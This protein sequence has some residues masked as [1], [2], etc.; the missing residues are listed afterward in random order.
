MYE[1]EEYDVIDIREVLQILRRHLKLLI[2]VPVIFAMLGAAV[3][4]FVIN[5]VYE[6]STTLIVRQNKGS[7]EEIDIGDV[8]LSKSLVYTYAEMAKSNTVIENTRKALGLKE[9]KDKSITVSPV[10]DTQILKVS[11]QDTN[12]Q[13]AM[14]I[15]NTLVEAFTTEIIRITK[16]DNVA[17]VDYAAMPEEPV[18]PNKA[19]NTAVAAILGEVSVLL[20][21]FLMEYLDNTVKSEKDIEKY[22]GVAVIGTIP[23]FNQGGKQTYGKVQSKRRSEVTHSGS[24]QESR[25]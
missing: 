11:V 12:P 19:V 17:V 7:D 23:N 6:A 15:A 4:I 18:K 10:K 8:N 20:V 25:C 16:T 3:S 1:N 5:P 22:L 21:V 13:L 9:L 14:D 24:V 2:I